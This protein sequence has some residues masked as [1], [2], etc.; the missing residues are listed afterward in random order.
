ML[1]LVKFR[2]LKRL[3]V[4]V[5]HVL[6]YDVSIDDE[7]VLPYTHIGHKDTLLLCVVFLY[8]SLDETSVFL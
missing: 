1:I 6:I 4:N 8:E 5:I 7:A 2:I 3:H